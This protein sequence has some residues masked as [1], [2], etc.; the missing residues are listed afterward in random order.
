MKLTKD[1]RERLVDF[2]S[3]SIQMDVKFLLVR[4]AAIYAKDFGFDPKALA[5][6]VTGLLERALM[7]AIEDLPG[8]DG[9]IREIFLDFSKE[10]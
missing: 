3:R 7:K 4:Q 5:D 6:S 8:M 10:M 1:S 9:E 2:L